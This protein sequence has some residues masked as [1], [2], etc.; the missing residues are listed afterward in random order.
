MAKKPMLE[1]ISKADFNKIHDASLKIL[2]ETG[3]VFNHEHAI[4]IF[5]RQGAK[6]LLWVSGWHRKIFI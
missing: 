4:E 1:V 2:K 3:V 5:K 6:V